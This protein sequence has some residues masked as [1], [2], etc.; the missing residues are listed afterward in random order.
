M[1]HTGKSSLRL[2]KHQVW[3]GEGGRGT[4]LSNFRKSSSVFQSPG[5]LWGLRFCSVTQK[6]TCRQVHV[7]D[8]SNYKSK[9]TFTMPIKKKPTPSQIHLIK[10]AQKWHF[11]LEENFKMPQVP[12][13]VQRAAKTGELPGWAAAVMTFFSFAYG[14][15][16]VSCPSSKLTFRVNSSESKDVLHKFVN[17]AR[18]N[19]GLNPL[20]PDAHYSERQDKS[21]II[22][23]FND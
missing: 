2:G 17:P 22:Y 4:A 15:F 5:S 18:L 16:Q 12:S 19:F 11:S 1:H 20:A 21:L 13:D 23:Q 14:H 7:P 10:D 8:Q 9:L 6:V 3:T